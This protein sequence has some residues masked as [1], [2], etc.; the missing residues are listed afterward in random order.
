MID[1]NLKGSPSKV[2][3]KLGDRG[4]FWLQ[5]ASD[6]GMLTPK[7]KHIGSEKVSDKSRI[8][9]YFQYLMVL[10]GERSTKPLHCQNKGLRDR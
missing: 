8:P 6:L 2:S 7:P 9:K 4:R 5:L 10:G 1:E 3:D